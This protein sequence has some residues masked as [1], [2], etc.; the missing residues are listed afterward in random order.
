MEVYRERIKEKMRKTREK[1]DE[2][3]RKGNR[4]EGR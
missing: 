3:E 4:D 2:R 1:E